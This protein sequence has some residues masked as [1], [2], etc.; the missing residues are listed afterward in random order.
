M[1]SRCPSWNLVLP[2]FW[3]FWRYEEFSA[4]ENIFLPKQQAFEVTIFFCFD[5][6][7]KFIEYLQNLG[8]IE[9]LCGHGAR[10]VEVKRFLG[11]KVGS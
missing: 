4:I 8:C 6:I 5:L 11:V 7:F 3:K 9:Q 1:A 2:K 10:M